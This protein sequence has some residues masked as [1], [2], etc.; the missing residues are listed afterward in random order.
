MTPISRSDGVRRGPRSPRPAAA[1][2]ARLDLVRDDP[3]AFLSVGAKDK[4]FRVA[5]M[6]R[7][8]A[9]CREAGVLHKFVLDPDLGHAYNPKPDVLRDVL[10]YFQAQ[11]SISAGQHCRICKV[12]HLAV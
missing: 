11:R 3:P 8:A 2:G 10:A 12:N 1:G 6:R 4:P 5:Q 9:R 7:L